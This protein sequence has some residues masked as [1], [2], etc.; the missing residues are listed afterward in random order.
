ML[1]LHLFLSEIE[2]GNGPQAFSAFL[3]A[4]RCGLAEWLHGWV[5]MG[6]GALTKPAVL[7]YLWGFGGGRVLS[8]LRSKLGPA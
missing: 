2:G 7:F 3:V 5:P 8:S 6:L 4:E 1:M